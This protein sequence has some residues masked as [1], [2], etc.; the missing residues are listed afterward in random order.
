MT[1]ETA[2]ELASA[3]LRSESASK[4]VSP[5]Q[6]AATE[7]DA[8]GQDALQSPPR[9]ARPPWTAARDLSSSIASNLASARGIPRDR[10]R[11]PTPITPTVSVQHAGGNFARE[12]A[13]PYD[14]APNERPESARKPSWAPP[15]STADEKEDSHTETP[16]SDGPFQQ[17]YSTF[18]SVISKLSAPLA[19]A[20][21]PL[22][23]PIT[24]KTPSMTTVTA[25][26]KRPK[27]PP[28]S[29]SPSVDYSQLISRA[30]LNALRDGP[31]HHN[32]AE[33]FYVVPTTG[34]TI[35]YAEVMSRAERGA[36][37]RPPEN[38]FRDQ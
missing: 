13:G 32:P 26:P 5:A 24:S 15:N 11:K 31:A 3:Q 22:T 28:V 37:W 8:R 25:K 10:L 4:G 12:Q 7:G 1:T 14:R 6:Q 19:F 36:G 27:T 34:G 33:S 35:S 20:G 16:S 30:A 18:E 21:L 23:S 38:S 2:A 9:L 29:S 17:F